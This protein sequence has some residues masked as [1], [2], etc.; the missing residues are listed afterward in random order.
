MKTTRERIARLLRERSMTPSELA[1]AVDSTP[2]C[3]VDDVQHVAQSVQGDAAVLVAPPVCRE[4]GFDGFR[5]SLLPSRCP[6]CKH[7]GI[8]EP[9][10][11]IDGAGP[12]E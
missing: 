11:T 4:C 1:A 10:F 8:D 9:A 5:D 2:A 12:V 7:E 3:V 6:E